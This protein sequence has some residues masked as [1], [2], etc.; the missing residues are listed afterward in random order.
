MRSFESV[1]VEKQHE[2]ME[3]SR[4][5]TSKVAKAKEEEK[6]FLNFCLI[7]MLFCFKNLPK[8]LINT[9]ITLRKHFTLHEIFF[10][11]YLMCRH[12]CLKR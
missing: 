6:H 8:S 5:N 2:H 12:D 10:K 11:Q 7:N 9:Y 1:D 3:I 4:A